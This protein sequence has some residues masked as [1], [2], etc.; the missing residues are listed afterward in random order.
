MFCWGDLEYALPGRDDADKNLVCESHVVLFRFRDEMRYR[1]LDARLSSRF[2]SSLAQES[3]GLVP[4][5]RFT[6]DWHPI[7]YSWKP[8]NFHKNNCTASR[9]ERTWEGCAFCATFFFWHAETGKRR[10]CSTWATRMEQG[11][12]K[13]GNK[14]R[15]YD[16]M[17]RCDRTCVI[18][19]WCKNYCPFSISVICLQKGC[20][21]VPF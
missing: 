21:F 17:S 12:N 20:F 6:A 8:I 4:D 15:K 7:G 13:K 18:L 11:A 19:K 9:Y 2:V 16:F 5:S 1:N 3:C 14:L 10:F